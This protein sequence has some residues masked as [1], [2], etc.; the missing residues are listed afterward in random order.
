MDI[1][2]DVRIG[3]KSTAILFGG[4][5]FTALYCLYLAF[6]IVMLGLGLLL[7]LGIY[8]YVGIILAVAVCLFFVRILKENPL[9]TTA[10]KAFLANA[11][12]GGFILFFIALDL[13]RG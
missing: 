2:D 1:R 8:Y 6:A 10:F 4:H 5:V 7:G 3:V 9:P 12:V 11:A 13:M